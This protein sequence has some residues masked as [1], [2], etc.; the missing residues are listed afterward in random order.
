MKPNRITLQQLSRNGRT[1][2]LNYRDRLIVADH[3]GQEYLF[4]EPCRIDAVTILVCLS[5]RLEYGVN[6]ERF[7]AE[8][9]CILVNMPQNIIQFFGATDLH[10]YVVLISPDLIDSMS[11]DMLQQAKSYLPMRQHYHAT[12]PIDEIA[13]LLPFLDLF[14]HNLAADQPETDDIVRSLLHAFMLSLLVLMRAHR[15]LSPVADL[16]AARGNRQVFERFM[17]AL[18]QHHQRE[19]MVQFYADQL[20]ITPKYLSMAVKEYSGKSP[21][22]WICDYVIA[23]AKSLLHYSQMPVQEVAFHLN[24]PTQSAFGKFFK[25]KTGISPSQYLRHEY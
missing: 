1:R 21:S 9:P 6:L 8:G 25:Q 4:E 11:R 17:E 13:P 10:A 5:G 2:M 24:F 16:S 15:V 18:S 7:E 3:I 19:R 12:V 22:D 14:K 23:E 20:C